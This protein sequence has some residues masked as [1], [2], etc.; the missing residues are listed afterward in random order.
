MSL[1]RPIEY[2]SMPGQMSVAVTTIESGSMEPAMRSVAQTPNTSQRIEATR[3]AMRTRSPA[4][5]RRAR[6]IHVERTVNCHLEQKIYQDEAPRRVSETPRCLFSAGRRVTALQEGGDLLEEVHAP[7]SG[8]TRAEVGAARAA[9][10]WR[11]GPSRARVGKALLRRG[12]PL[13]IQP[14]S[15]AQIPPRAAASVGRRL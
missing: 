5:V 12:N 14:C 8:C 3:V 1:G 10:A 6:A 9:P 7:R 4:F 15:H 11:I 2:A 13:P